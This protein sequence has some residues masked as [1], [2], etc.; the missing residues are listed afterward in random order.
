MQPLKGKALLTCQA[1]GNENE[2]LVLVLFSTVADLW[3]TQSL[4]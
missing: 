1:P 4:L 3:Y 2:S